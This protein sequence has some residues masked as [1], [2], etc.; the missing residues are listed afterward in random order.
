MAVSEGKGE[1]GWAG[2]GAIWAGWLP[3]ASQVGCWLYPFIFFLVFSFSFVSEICFVF[4]K[5]ILF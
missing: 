1:L 3:G 4:F 2:S 5:A